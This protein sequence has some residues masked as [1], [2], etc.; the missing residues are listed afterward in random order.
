M[1]MWTT[2]WNGGDIQNYE[3]THRSFVT[4]VSF[5]TGTQA[6]G[7]FYVD[8]VEECQIT[9][10]DVVFDS[11]F[12]DGNLINVTYQDG[13][14]DGYRYYTAE[15]DY[16]MADFPD[17][18]WWFYYSMDEV[19]GKTIEIELQNLAPEDFSDGRWTSHE[20][21]YSYDNLN[22]ERVPL[23][24]C[25]LQRCSENL[26]RHHHPHGKHGLAGSHPPLHRDDG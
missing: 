7:D 5:S 15:V 18:H 11:D 2:H 6:Q 21:V 14:V 3:L 20:P 13:D 12:E 23:T 16:S 26:Y 8:N 17:K 22:W 4:H 9:Y 24:G 10:D 19:A 25:E 1:Y